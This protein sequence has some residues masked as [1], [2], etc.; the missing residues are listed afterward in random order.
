MHQISSSD[1]LESQDREEEVSIHIIQ[2]SRVS[3]FLS[4]EIH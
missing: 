3:T 2:I 4:M 1:H